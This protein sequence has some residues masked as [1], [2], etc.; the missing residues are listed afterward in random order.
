MSPLRVDRVE[1]K[2][3]FK[4]FLLFPWSVYRHNPNWVPPLISE[5]KEKLDPARN[6][7]FEHAEG[8]L[9]LARK[10]G[11]IMGRIAALIDHRH[12]S[13][14]QEKVV[15]FGFYESRDDLETARALLAAAADWG[16]ARGMNTLRGPMN[17]SMNDECAFLVDGFDRPPVVMMPY[18]PP[19]YPK[20]MEGCGLT[21]AKDLLAFFLT[22]DHEA[23]ERANAIA[24]EFRRQTNIQIRALEKKTVD[25]DADRI[26]QIYNSAWE[27]N[28]GFVPWTENEIKFMI[29]KLKRIAD[30]RLVLLAEEENGRPV[31]F[32][33]GLPNFNEVLKK[34]NGRLTPLSQLKFLFYRRRIQGMRAVVFGIVQEYRRSG[35]SYYLYSEL[36]KNAIRAGYQW[37]E[38]SWL[39]EDNEPVIKFSLSLGAKIYK[40]YRIY[41]K[42]IR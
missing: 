32:A 42:M 33:L 19:Y 24:E 16:K 34:M 37:G 13:V 38:M 6:P 2:M 29:A 15:F 28:W 23:A 27:K 39:L 30:M 12:N 7:F 41:E 3:D 31:G 5:I 1:T 35:L 9:F 17:P 22:R 40:T 18:N 4:D 14:H 8:Q 11:Q 26:V 20:L 25:R 10:D 36:E 21:K